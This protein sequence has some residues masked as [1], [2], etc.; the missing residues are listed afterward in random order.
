MENREILKQE[1]EK[2]R[3]ELSRLIDSQG[4]AEALYRLSV[5][6]DQLIAQYMGA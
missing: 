1:I 2:K 4:E 3:E 5:E 6:L